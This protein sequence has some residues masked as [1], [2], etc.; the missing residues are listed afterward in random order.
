MKRNFILSFIA[1]MILGTMVCSGVQNV[2]NKDR[3]KRMKWFR[4][5]KFGLFIHWGTYAIPAGEWK[6]KI[7]QGASEWL[8]E[9][10]QIPVKEYELLAKDFNPVKFNAEQWVKMAKDAGMKY[11][12]ITS[13]HHEGFAMFRT[14]ASRYNIIDA[15]PFKRDPIKELADACKKY[16]LRLGFYYS[17]TKDWHEPNAGGNDW[18]FK[19]DK[20]DNFRKY[21]DEKVIPQVTE[22]LTQYGPISTIWF[23]TPGFM[24]PEQ[25]KELADLVHKYQPD[26]LIDGRVGNNMGDYKTKGDNKLPTGAT[27]IDWDTP[28]TMNDSWG[29]KK[30]DENWKSVPQ[31]IKAVV[32]VTSKGGVYLLNVGPTAEGLIPQPSIDRLQQVGKWLKVNGDAIYNTKMS[33][34]TIEPNWGMV[35]TKP[36]KLFLHV[37]DWPKNGK[38]ELLGLI[39]KVKKA[40]LLANKKI[41]KFEQKEDASLKLNSLSISIPP[42]PTDEVVSVIA[43]DIEDEAK[44]DNRILQQPDG[45]I[46]LNAVQSEIHKGIGESKIRKDDVGILDWLKNDESVSWEFV[47]AKP[48]TYDVS[49]A[50]FEVKRG[51]GRNRKII[52]EGGHKLLITA[53]GQELHF[54]TDN[55]KKN[56][57]KPSPYFEDIVSTNGKISF[58]GPGNYGSK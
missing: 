13:K 2:E 29:Y 37:F 30:S 26:C 22:I 14:K 54:T 5:A 17:Q 42:A 39:S 28:A 57:D 11:I 51:S 16:G 45:V 35:T 12:V 25:S 41:L 43:L 49:I 40:T 27:D 6:G 32:E 10:A 55:E 46:T 47:V 34:F 38:L 4:D 48:G 24:T 18:D 20:P 23:D 44:V 15:T 7:Y 36:G 58:P 33:P 19:G 3:D 56:V 53:A 21:L 9:R 52:Y 31:L 8:Q 1:L 50:S